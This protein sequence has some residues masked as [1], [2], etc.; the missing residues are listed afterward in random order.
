MDGRR[1]FKRLALL[2]CVCMYGVL[3]L[4]PVSVAPAE[5]KAVSIGASVHY[6]ISENGTLVGWGATDRRF[7]PYSSGLIPYPYCL[8]RTVLRNVASVYTNGYNT[9]LA[10]DEDGDLW[11]WGTGLS[12]L[13]LDEYPSFHRPV[14]LMENVTSVAM[15]KDHGAA[16]KTD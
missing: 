11:G 13:L 12:I 4:V 1:L 5:H 8:R 10:I 16:I 9:I 7:I 2:A 6:V 3:L 14:K 15:G